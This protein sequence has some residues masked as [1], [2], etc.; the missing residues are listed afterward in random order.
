MNIGFVSREYPPFFGGG[1]GTYVYQM[2]RALAAAGHQ[3]QVFTVRT[4]AD[5]HVADPPGVHVH[6]VAYAPPG[7]DEGGLSGPWTRANGWLHAARLFRDQVLDFT[8]KHKLDVVELPEWEAPGWLLLLDWRWNVPTVVN[9]HTPTW[10]LQELNLQAPLAGQRLEKL[11]LALADAVCAPCTPMARRVARGVDLENPITVVAH[12]YFAEDVVA[13]PVPPTGKRLLYVGRLEHRKGVIT[14]IDAAQRVLAAEPDAE[15]LL[16]GGDTNTRPG[17]GSMKEFLENRIAPEYRDRIRFVDN[18][19]AHE[20]FPLFADAAFCVF[21]SIF[22]NF[23]NVCLE[24]MAAGRTAVVGDDSG[25]V[26]MLG[27]AGVTVPPQDVEALTA[28]VLALL[29]DPAR[30]QTL[31]H[32]AWRR[33]REVF[34]PAK[35]A[36]ERAAFYDLVRRRL[37]GRSTLKTR[38]ARVAPSV[39]VDTMPEYAATF[40]QLL[41]GTRHEG[42]AE[43]PLVARVLQRVHLLLPDVRQVRV[44]LYGAGRHT[45]QLAPFFHALDRRGVTVA[46]VLD[47]EPSRHGTTIGGVMVAGPQAALEAQLDAVVLSSDAAEPLLWEKSSALRNAGMLVIRLYA[48]DD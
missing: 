47:D 43:D 21:P 18:V 3:V 27:D 25:M 17:G 9:C 14:L 8:R 33:G 10:L 15:L 38:L 5:D 29:R 22:E 24:A 42:A 31:G 28:A 7:P 20:L 1:V 19:P 35:I 48:I 44:A 26:E 41:T 6:R 45:Q 32:R 30:V 2:S 23:P 46:M 39:W 4:G 37:D 40:R 16:V 11:Q 36:A 12:P 13:E 34:A